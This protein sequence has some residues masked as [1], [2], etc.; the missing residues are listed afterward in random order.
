M[1]RSGRRCGGFVRGQVVL[2]QVNAVGGGQHREVRPIIDDQRSPGLVG[3]RRH[4]PRVGQKGA[5]GISF[6]RTW[7]AAAPPASTPRRTSSHDR[8]H[9]ARVR[10]THRPPAFSPADGRAASS[11]RFSKS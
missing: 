9:I 1:I 2:P 11:S 6:S 7:T 5:V 10:R 3:H 4:V 8:R